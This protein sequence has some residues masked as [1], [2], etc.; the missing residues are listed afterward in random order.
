MTKHQLEFQKREFDSNIKESK[1]QLER[2]N[3]IL[4]DKLEVGSNHTESNITHIENLTHKIECY[5][6]QLDGVLK[7]LNETV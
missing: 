4:Q 2:A 5:Y 1:S 3:K 6:R 7:Q